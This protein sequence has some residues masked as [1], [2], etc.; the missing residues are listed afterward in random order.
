MKSGE[1]LLQAIGRLIEASLQQC[2]DF[3]QLVHLEFQLARTAFARLIF[4]A[5]L[6]LFMLFSTWLSLQVVFFIILFT[7]GVSLLYTSLI[8]FLLN[9]IVMFILLFMIKHVK[10]QLSFHATRKQL[11][12]VFTNQNEAAHE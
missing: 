11:Q 3:V 10:K 12:H 5:I 8:L 1:N 4:F 6:L 7:H 2:R 9:M